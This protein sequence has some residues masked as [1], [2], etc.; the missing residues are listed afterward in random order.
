MYIQSLVLLQE[1]VQGLTITGND[2]GDSLL[3]VR[4][5]DIY[6]QGIDGATV[7]NNNLG[8]NYLTTYSSNVT[9]VWFATGTVNSSILNNNITDI[10]AT[11][12]GPRGL[13][14]SSAYPNA[15]ILISGNTITGM[16]TA[17]SAP[18]YGIYVFSTTSGVVVKK[19]KISGLLNTNTGGYGARGINI[20]TSVSP[21][22]IDIVNNF[23]W[24]IVA[25]ADASVTYY[26]VGIAID[27]TI[28]NVNVY[29][30]SVNMYG[31]FA[32]Y[33]SATVHT[34]LY[35]S[36]GVTILNLRDN[37]FKKF[38]QQSEQCNR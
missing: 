20:A 24:N 28:S 15:N 17:G 35:I 2:I 25:T 3:P 38:I 36:S 11:A 5:V 9:G 19:N 23:V 30:N 33:T 13:A 18:P 27:A 29:S 10:T 31:S 16:Q 21:A 26:G 1:T 6:V 7:S 37:I 22:N 32:G 4:L 14:I 34:A 12:G 8:K